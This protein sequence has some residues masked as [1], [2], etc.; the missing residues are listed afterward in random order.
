MTSSV[1][2]NPP[3]H[4][5][6]EPAQQLHACNNLL[7]GTVNILGLEMNADDVIRRVEAGERITVTTDH[8]PV[9]E[10]I[11]LR[12]RTWTWSPRDEAVSILRKTMSDPE[13]ADVLAELQAEPIPTTVGIWEVTHHISKVIHRA[14]AGEAMLV[15]DH[16]R[17]IAVIVP[18]PST[19]DP[20]VDQLIRE[21]KLTPARNPGGIAALLALEPV[22]A[23]NGEDAAAVVSEFRTDHA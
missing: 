12:S 19:G 16:N 18:L 2:I 3:A 17:P 20:A 8:R 9:A 14:A 11:P 15:I 22:A 4:A 21:G 6:A 23:S 13:V 5:P 10:I 1:T 7:V